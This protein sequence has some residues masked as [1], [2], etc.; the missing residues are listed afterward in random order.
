MLLHRSEGT[1]APPRP[2]A[3]GSVRRSAWPAADRSVADAILELTRWGQLLCNAGRTCHAYTR[4]VRTRYVS[5]GQAKNESKNDLGRKDMPVVSG[6]NSSD[7][8]LLVVTR[9]LRLFTP[10]NLIQLNS[11]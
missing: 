9:R 10:C 1:A 6:C 3:R 11:V 8:D 4:N 2:T 5:Y 7:L